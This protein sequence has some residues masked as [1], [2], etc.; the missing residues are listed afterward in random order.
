MLRNKFRYVNNS[1]KN[2]S[3]GFLP[4]DIT[5]TFSAWKVL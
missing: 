3:A 2:K 5:I 1:D 4:A